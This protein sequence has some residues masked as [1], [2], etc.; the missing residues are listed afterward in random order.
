LNVD[1]WIWITFVLIPFSVD[2]LY[3][4][5]GHATGDVSACP[6]FCFCFRVD[7]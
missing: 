2:H 6:C 4:S 3:T 5:R 7:F 1:V